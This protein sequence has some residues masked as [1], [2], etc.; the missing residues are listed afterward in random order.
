MVLA[1]YKDQLHPNHALLT[2]TKQ[3]LAA[4]LGRVDG[5]RYDQLGKED[6]QLK[7][8]ISN[9]LLTICSVLEPGISKSQ[10]ITLLDLTETKARLL[11]IEGKENQKVLE[12]LVKIEK[13]L[14]VAHDI[15]QYEDEKALEGNVAKQARIQLGQLRGHIVGLRNTLLKK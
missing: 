4:A 5:Y 8:R 13:E 11:Q 7:I 14:K 2:E 15:L 3:H 9:D 10:G 12:E 1:K 6:L